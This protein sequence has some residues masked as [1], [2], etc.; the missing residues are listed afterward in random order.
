MY[1]IIESILVGIYTLFI[2][3]SL[4]YVVKERPF[5]LVLFLLGI[6]KHFGGYILGLHSEYCKYYKSPSAKAIAPTLIETVLEGLLFVII[7]AFLSMII[8]NK[9][10]IV[11]TIGFTLHTVF[12]IAGFHEYY[13]T[14][15]CIY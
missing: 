5:T 6:L 13:I 12:Q 1:Y 9:Y 4:L 3:I 7:G 2:Y 15:R 10:I 8:K 11:W 14:Y